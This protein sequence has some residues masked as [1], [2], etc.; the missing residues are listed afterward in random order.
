MNTDANQMQPFDKNHSSYNQKQL[1]FGLGVRYL[2]AYKK[3][4]NVQ[5]I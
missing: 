2:K 1:F 3:G 5:G 4:Y